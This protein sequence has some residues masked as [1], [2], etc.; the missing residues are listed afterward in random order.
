MLLYHVARTT[1]S[2]PPFLVP[3][4]WVKGLVIRA[5]SYAL[6]IRSN[7]AWLA[8][9]SLSV[10]RSSRGAVLGSSRIFID[11]MASAAI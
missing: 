6:A 11:K 7:V 4:F 1:L 9:R 2:S 5:W 10:F 8:L 3:R